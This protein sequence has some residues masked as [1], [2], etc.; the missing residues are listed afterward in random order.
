[1]ATY[2]P[3]RVHPQTSVSFRCDDPTQLAALLQTHGYRPIKP[4][5]HEHARLRSAAGAIAVLFESGSVLVQG[6]HK[7]PLLDLLQSLCPNTILALNMGG[8]S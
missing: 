2:T 4:C 7:Q 6:T 5:Q 3:L 8:V 1:M